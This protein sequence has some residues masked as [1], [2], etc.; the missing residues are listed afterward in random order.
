MR[1]FRYQETY[2][3]GPVDSKFRR[4]SSRIEKQNYALGIVAKFASN[5]LRALCRSVESAF[6]KSL[7]NTIG[8]P[9]GIFRPT[10]FD[11]RR[12]SARRTGKRRFVKG[13]RH[14]ASSY[15]SGTDIENVE[16][17]RKGLLIQ[18]GL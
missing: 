4:H 18:N 5:E 2:G 6:R 14:L 16:H 1:V 12:A 7:Q 3:V 8:K 13:F 10:V 17:A 9:L 15:V 11:K